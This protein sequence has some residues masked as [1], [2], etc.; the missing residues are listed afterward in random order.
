MSLGLDGSKPSS[1]AA[2]RPPPGAA[3]SAERLGGT[4]PGA[5]PGAPGAA[6]A[7]APRRAARAAEADVVEQAA[8]PAARPA[9]SGRM[10]FDHSFPTASQYRLTGLI[11]SLGFGGGGRRSGTCGGRGAP[12][13]ASISARPPSRAPPERR[14]AA[15]LRGDEHVARAHAARGRG[16]ARGDRDDAQQRARVAR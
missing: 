3:S 7:G 16:R 11:S 15:A 4:A 5:A 13:T 6:A 14:A 12:R 9:P 1:A 8:Q 10:S 2:A